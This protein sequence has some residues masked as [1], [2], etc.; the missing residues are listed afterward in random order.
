MSTKISLQFKTKYDGE[1]LQHGLHVRI[2]RVITS[3]GFKTPNG[4]TIPFNAIVDTGN[5]VT[6]LPEI[7]HRHIE[8]KVLYPHPVSLYGVGKGQVSARL[9]EV[10]MLFVGQRKNSP[11][12]RL[13][14]Y[15]LP[16]DSLPVLIGFEDILTNLRFV[17][18]YSRQR[19]QFEFR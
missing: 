8:R 4:W 2:I 3:A 10:E 5:P 12:L 13:K 6:I 17:S 11:S 9:A 15:L 19:V 1:L 7:A 16:D 18:D 14:A